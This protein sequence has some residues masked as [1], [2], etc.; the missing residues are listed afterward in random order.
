M[1]VNTIE[2]NTEAFESLVHRVN[3]MSGKLYTMQ[4]LENYLTSSKVVQKVKIT[5][6]EQVGGN[7]MEGNLYRINVHV[8]TQDGWKNKL[9]KIYT[10]DS[11]IEDYGTQDG[12]ESFKQ[13]KQDLQDGLNNLIY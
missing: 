5:L 11:W 1:A 7:D 10:N 3:L 4:A 12:S 9:V 6:V 13:M 8:F 2:Q